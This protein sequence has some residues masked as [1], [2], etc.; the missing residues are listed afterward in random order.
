[1]HTLEAD[2]IQLAFADRR[3]LSDIY[4]KCE[5]GKIT[6][7]LGRNGEGKS[8]LMKIIYGTLNCEKSVRIDN[9]AYYIP[10]KRP[11][12]IRYLPQFNF[13]PKSFSLKR[14]FKDYELDYSFF[15]GKFPEFSQKQNSSIDGMSGGQV[16]L[17][18]LYII[19][20]S[21]TSFV[22]L[23]EPFTHLS[24]LHVEKVKELI[25]EEKQNKG[26]LLTDHMF[27]HI[28]D[29]ADSLY[30]LT[31]GKTHLTKSTGDIETL[32]YAPETFSL[33]GRGEKEIKPY[34]PEDE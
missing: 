5:T 34:P 17:A 15:E 23:D 4:L 14:V 20:K 22:L 11:E 30:L 25:L 21:K 26:L 18:E 13:I 29:I 7:L 33:S 9:V 12:L 24:P 31:K 32:G 19:L 27:S 1:M 16:R 8:C 10:F 3:I 6:G 28:T 2:S